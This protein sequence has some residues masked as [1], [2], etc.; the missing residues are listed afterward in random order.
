MSS[1]IK[2]TGVVYNRDWNSEKEPN[3]NCSAEE[4]NKL[5]EDSIRKHWE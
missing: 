2:L 1:E 4:I 3:R 5:H